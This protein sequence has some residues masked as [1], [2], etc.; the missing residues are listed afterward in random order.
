MQKTLNLY[1][2]EEFLKDYK[3]KPGDSA[4]KT[5]RKG[6]KKNHNFFL[7]LSQIVSKIRDDKKE[8]FLIG[9]EV[10][11]RLAVGGFITVIG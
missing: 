5:N 3:Q 1:G 4:Y 7:F 9:Q 2:V 8:V 10:E 11:R 6:T